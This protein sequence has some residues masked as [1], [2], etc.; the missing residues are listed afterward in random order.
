M[1]ASERTLMLPRAELQ[2][3][4]RVDTPR[5]PV[6]VWGARRPG[7]DRPSEDSALIHHDGD[8]L[9][10]AVADGAGGHAL[11]GE[12]S[13]AAVRAIAWTLESGEGDIRDRIRRARI[14]AVDAVARLGEEAITTVALTLIH[15][16]EVRT[17]HA[18]DSTILLT[19]QR[20]RRKLRTTDHTVPGLEAA[21]GRMTLDEAR[22]HEER[23]LLVNALGTEEVGWE[24]VGPVPFAA[25]DTLLLAT[26]GLFDNL[27][28]DE[29]VAFVRS[30]PLE[31]GIRALVERNHARMF[32]DQGP[33]PGKPDD[34]V[35][36]AHRPT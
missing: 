16:N 23:H 35:V 32:E 8:T 6:I 31:D 28:D 19:G 3:V 33:W 10:M 15:E 25:R 30:G 7:A 18:G 27:S 5:G 14:E 24:T 26:D 12:A 36:L 13:E 34:V 22:A 17:W 4:G 1:G 9:V 20:G 11:G 21:A 29:I 2:G